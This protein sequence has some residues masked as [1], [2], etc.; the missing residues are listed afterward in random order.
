MVSVME[1]HL[2]QASPIK[3]LSTFRAQCKVLFFFRRQLFVFVDCHPSLL[4]PVRSVV[5]GCAI[6]SP[7]LG[8]IRAGAGARF[9]Q[10]C[11]LL[12]QTAEFL[13]IDIQY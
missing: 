13:G 3:Y 5:V 7:R 10:C 12:R 11:H 1:K 4:A 6:L 2:V 8:F 9:W